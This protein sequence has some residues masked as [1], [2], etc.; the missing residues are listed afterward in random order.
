MN[1]FRFD[2]LKIGMRECFRAE[3]SSEKMHAFRE[4][5]GDCNPL[6]N[7]ES[8]AREKGF[9]DKVAFGMLSSSFLSTLAGVYLPGDHSL[10]QSVEVKFLK[11]VYSGDSLLVSGEISEMNSTVKQ[12]V[13]KVSMENQSGERVLKGK[14][15]VIVNE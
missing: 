6:H 4:L 11:P 13:L 14:M 5:S 10:I 9:R 15:K 2:E 8:Y 12:I 7:D 3:V 1:S